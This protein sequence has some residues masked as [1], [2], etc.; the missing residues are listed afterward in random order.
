[1]KLW[2]HQGPLGVRYSPP[3]S[4]PLYMKA[5]SEIWVIPLPPHAVFRSKR[6]GTKDLQ[7]NDSCA[8]FG[9]VMFAFTKQR[10]LSLEHIAACTASAEAL[11]LKTQL[12]GK[13]VECKWCQVCPDVNSTP[14]PPHWGYLGMFQVSQGVIFC[15]GLSFA[16]ASF[17]KT[18]I[19]FLLIKQIKLSIGRKHQVS[20][21]AVCLA[22]HSG[23]FHVV[24]KEYNIKQISPK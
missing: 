1:M 14:L 10:G 7:K 24:S 23:L 6:L 18:Q 4:F 2:S 19:L 16:N 22:L 11:A 21:W 17:Y 5:D 8:F 9:L 15:C 20:G 13:L 3:D 12:S